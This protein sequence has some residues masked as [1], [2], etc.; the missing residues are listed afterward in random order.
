MSERDITRERCPERTASTHHL[1]PKRDGRAFVQ[2]CTY[3][4]KTS[5]QIRMSPAT[6]IL[7]L[8]FTITNTRRT[9]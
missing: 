4:G 3:C 8:S 9:R 6:E 7:D 2:A 1:K 5:Q